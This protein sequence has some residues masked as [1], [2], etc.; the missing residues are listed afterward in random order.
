MIS[1]S[2]LPQEERADTELVKVESPLSTIEELPSISS[3]GPCGALM[4]V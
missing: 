2:A 3:A 1:L 4:K